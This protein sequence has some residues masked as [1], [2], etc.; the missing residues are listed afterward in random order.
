MR[1]NDSRLEA[2][3]APNVVQGLGSLNYVV[4]TE[5]VELPSK[6][7]LYPSDHPLYNKE[8]VE[9][10]HMTAK[11]EDI[12]T[13]LNLIEKGVVLDY[14]IQSLLINK[15]INCKNLL[16]GDRSAILLNARMNGYGA[17]YKFKLNCSKCSEEIEVECN[18]AEIKNKEIDASINDSGLMTL[19]LPKTKYPVTLR[20][21]TDHEEEV[22]Q[23][24][25]EKRKNMGFSNESTTIFLQ[26]IVIS[27]NGVK[28]EGNS[29]V[30]FIQNMPSLDAKYI[31]TQYAQSKP[32]ID[33][34]I[35]FQCSGCG[36][37]E[38]REVPLTAQFFWPES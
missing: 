22:L 21:L 36:H 2:P 25:I 27:I 8:Y 1:Q 4:P 24:E 20:F 19:E 30:E 35:D 34:S 23:K 14:L 6:G 17:D 10:K 9:I 31:Q 15:D 26:F 28:N 18:L 5:L 32:D 37:P 7:I 12:L 16:A 13:S 33:F 3:S 38:R 29:L 11:E